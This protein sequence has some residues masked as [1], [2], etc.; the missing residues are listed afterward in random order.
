MPS[1][2]FGGW[3]GSG[4]PLPVCRKYLPREGDL[5]EPG[6]LVGDGAWRPPDTVT[7]SYRDQSGDGHAS[8]VPWGAVFYGTLP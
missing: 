6:W 1:L 3:Q 4:G 7:E 2:T 8:P 5:A